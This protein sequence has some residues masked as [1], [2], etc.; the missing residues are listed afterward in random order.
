MAI[1]MRSNVLH[2]NTETPGRR[3]IKS[4][5]IITFLN[6]QS[7]DSTCYEPQYSTVVSMIKQIAKTFQ[8]K[9]ITSTVFRRR[10]LIIGKKMFRLIHYYVVV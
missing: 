8:M 9:R 3:N 4:R 10:V 7:V 6:Q 5:L 1:N 2:Y